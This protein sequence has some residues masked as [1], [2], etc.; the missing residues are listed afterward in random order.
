MPEARRD[1]ARI[2]FID[3]SEPDNVFHEMVLVAAD[4]AGDVMAF[5]S[6][7]EGVAYLRA[8]PDGPVDLVFLDINMPAT[9]GWAVLAALKPDLAHWPDLRIYMLTSSSSPEDR[10]RAARTPG[11]TGYLTKPLE[12]DVVRQLLAT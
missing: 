6:P 12:T 10:E 1:V 8:Q 7:L 11:V 9:D 4:F 5:E 3:D 2:V